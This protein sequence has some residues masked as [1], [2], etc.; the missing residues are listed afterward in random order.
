MLLLLSIFYTIV[1]SES[2]ANLICNTPGICV[3]SEFVGKY[4]EIDKNYDCISL[5]L[6]HEVCNWSSFDEKYKECLL[7]A[8][9]KKIDIKH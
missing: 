1:K 3:N 8:N 9:C 4:H 5:C 7:F 6:N 2:E